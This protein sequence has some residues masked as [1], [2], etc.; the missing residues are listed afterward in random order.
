[1]RHEKNDETIAW[2]N[3]DLKMARDA[4]RTIRGSSIAKFNPYNLAW[5]HNRLVFWNRAISSDSDSSST[6]GKRKAM[7]VLED[8]LKIIDNGYKQEWQ[9]ECIDCCK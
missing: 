6:D 4:L 9:A 7:K 2:L 1:M 5:L 3:Q 8:L